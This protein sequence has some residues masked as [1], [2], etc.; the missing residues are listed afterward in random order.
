MAGTKKLTP[1]ETE[2]SVK[3]TVVKKVRQHK[4]GAPLTEKIAKETVQDS[5]DCEEKAARSRVRLQ[6]EIG[7]QVLGND[8]LTAHSSRAV[9]TKTVQDGDDGKGKLPLESNAVLKTK[10]TE[11]SLT[12]KAAQKKREA[13]GEK[14]A[15]GILKEAILKAAIKA[16][17]Q[18]GEDGL[19]SYLEAQA[20][21]N[22]SSFLTLLGKVLPAELNAD[23]QE[24]KTVT[25]IE[26]VALSPS[27][28]DLTVAK[29]P[30][31]KKRMTSKKRPARHQELGINQELSE[32]LKKDD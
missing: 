30:T 28:K 2:K 20:L 5:D 8:K 4:N 32:I 11:K 16:G 26:L 19:V 14:K 15:S 22:A 21:K 17:N 10:P 27:P 18:L 12:K 23:G 7:Q 25:K 31:G 6:K 13:V 9:E 3:K 1:P 29:S 24:L